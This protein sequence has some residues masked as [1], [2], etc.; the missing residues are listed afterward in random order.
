MTRGVQLRFQK[1]IDEGTKEYTWCAIDLSDEG[2]YLAEEKEIY[3]LITSFR[4]GNKQ[5]FAINQKLYIDKMRKCAS[6][7]F[8]VCSNKRFE[9]FDEEMAIVTAEAFEHSC[10]VEKRGFISDFN[11]MWTV[12]CKSKCDLKIK[13]SIVGFQKLCTLLSEMQKKFRDENLKIS[14]GHTEKFL[15]IANGL[16]CLLTVS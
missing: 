7:A 12:R 6:E 15:K 16:V 3:Q 14:E 10:N 2:R 4:E 13:E 9:V 8:T 11:E 5:M 1:M